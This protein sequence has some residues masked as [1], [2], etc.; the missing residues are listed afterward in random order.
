MT[1]TFVLVHGA[2]H[3][4]G[5]FERL[6]L[7]LAQMGYPSRTVKLPSAGPDPRGGMPEDAAA[8]RAVIGRVDGPVAVLGHSYGG[9]PVTEG[10]AGLPQVTHLVYLAAYMPDEG[11]SMFRLH[12]APD[13]EDTDDLFP[14][15]ADPRNSLYGSLTGDEAAEAIAQ[16]VEQRAQAF[17]DRV[18]VAA[19]HTVPSTYIVTEDD[20]AIP[21]AFQE[22]MAVQ[23][24]SVRRIPGDHSPFLSRPA[25]LAALL[26]D[27]VSGR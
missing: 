17:G 6:Q 24:K 10:A 21:A 7:A 22:Q 9:I 4:P 8:I 2:W 26:D 3:R 14:L 23:A 20:R 1:T 19:W 12:G 11:Q 5:S 13:P 27:I 18:T 15:I 16:L 25:E